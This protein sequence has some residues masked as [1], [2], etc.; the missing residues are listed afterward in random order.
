MGRITR[1]EAGKG[2]GGFGDIERGKEGE[3]GKGRGESWMGIEGATR[4]R[5][6]EERG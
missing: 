3:L 6:E 4:E 2:D 5:K 1:R